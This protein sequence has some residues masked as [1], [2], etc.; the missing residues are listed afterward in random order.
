MLSLA[1]SSC[2][3]TPIIAGA[4][5]VVRR[6]KYEVVQFTYFIVCCHRKGQSLCLME[7]PIRQARGLTASIHWNKSVVF[8]IVIGSKDIREAIDGTCIVSYANN[9]AGVTFVAQ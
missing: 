6:L 4:P 5:F 8:P 9:V 2:K 3:K 7:L 1:F